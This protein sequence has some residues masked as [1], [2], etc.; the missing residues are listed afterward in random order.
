MIAKNSCRLLLAIAFTSLGL[1]GVRADDPLGAQSSP[2]DSVQQL[3]SKINELRKEGKNEEANKLMIYS[4]KAIMKITGAKPQSLPEIHADLPVL[5]GDA[6]S[7]DGEPHLARAEKL[8]SNPVNGSALS[9]EQRVRSL[10]AAA[11]SLKAAGLEQDAA[12][13]TRMASQLAQEGPSGDLSALQH[14]IAEL[15]T[16][17]K[18]LC[19]EV[20]DLKGMVSANRNTLPGTTYLQPQNTYPVPGP[21]PGTGLAEPGVGVAR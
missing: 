3:Q 13:Y 4:A 7:R 11:S 18:R 2:F 19:K 12:R 9:R 8:Q 16:Q 1:S 17:V 20:E 6:P 5:P 10:L 21:V 14:E 15:R